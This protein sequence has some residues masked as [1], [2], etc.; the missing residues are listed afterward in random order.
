MIIQLPVTTEVLEKIDDLNP[1]GRVENKQILIEFDT[2]RRDYRQE[3]GLPR[4]TKISWCNE[5]TFDVQELSSFPW[6][7]PLC[8]YQLRH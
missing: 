5:R 2:R 8:Q 6:P 7:I 3:L 4:K 1:K